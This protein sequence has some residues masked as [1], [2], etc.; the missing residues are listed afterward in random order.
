M[1]CSRLPEPVKILPTSVR[2]VSFTALFNV[3]WSKTLLE[4]FTLNICSSSETACA[5]RGKDFLA[6]DNISHTLSLPPV[7]QLITPKASGKFLD[8]LLTFPQFQ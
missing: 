6:V 4:Q 7:I 1:N 8:P 5:M 3:G 2:K